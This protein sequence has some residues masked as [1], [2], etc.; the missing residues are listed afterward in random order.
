MFNPDEASLLD[1]LFG[2]HGALKAWHDDEQ[3]RERMAALWQS[4]QPA[5]ELVA[6]EAEARGKRHRKARLLTRVAAE[7][8]AS[9]EP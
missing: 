6:S 5:A 7:P 3:I 8:A 4:L 9:S 2:Q 1:D